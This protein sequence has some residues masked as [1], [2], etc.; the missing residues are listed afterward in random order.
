MSGKVTTYYVVMSPY[1]ADHIK[2]LAEDC[3]FDPSVY[4][5]KVT[6][7]VKAYFNH[8]FSHEFDKRPVC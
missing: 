8:E 7:E 6:P 2:E 4:L 1:V 3:T 5:G